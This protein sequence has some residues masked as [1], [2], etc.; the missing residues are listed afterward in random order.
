MT[1]KLTRST[2]LYLAPRFAPKTRFAQC[3]TCRDWVTGDRRCVIHGPK[4]TVPGTA[5]CGFYVWGV[6]KPKGTATS[7]KVTPEE[8]GLVDREVRCENCTWGD[9][10]ATLCGLYRILNQKMPTMFDLDEKI[11]PHGCCN[12]QQ[13]R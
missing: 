7:A 9:N 10:G 5:S 12:A 6:P 1:G 2:F 13:P 11:D 3:S 8:S 4:V